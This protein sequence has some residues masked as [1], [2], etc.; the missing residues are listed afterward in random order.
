MIEKKDILKMVRHIMKRGRGI[1]DKRLMHPV[2]EWLLG[3][4]GAVAVVVC[5]VLYSTQLF[6]TY[7]KVTEIEQTDST[8]SIRYNQTVIDDARAQFSARSERFNEL[9]GDRPAPPPPEVAT[10]TAT[11]TESVETT[12]EVEGETLPLLVE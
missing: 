4:L 10:S 9:R 7:D 1:P 12:E 5:G 2:R 8:I 3:L 11:T 6:T